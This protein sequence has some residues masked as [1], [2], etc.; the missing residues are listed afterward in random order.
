MSFTLAMWDPERGQAAGHLY[1]PASDPVSFTFF[2]DQANPSM[3]ARA[4]N[5][6]VIS[7]DEIRSALQ[8]NNVDSQR[9]AFVVLDRI[10]RWNTDPELAPDLLELLNGGPT[11][12]TEI[13]GL[14]AT[15]LS[16]IEKIHTYT[17]RP[18]SAFVPEDPADE[19][20][21]SR[22][23]ANWEL[24]L[25]L[26]SDELEPAALTYDIVGRYDEEP[27]CTQDDWDD[28]CGLSLTLQC[29]GVAYWNQGNE[30]VTGTWTVTDARFIIEGSPPELGEVLGQTVAATEPVNSLGNL[31]K[32]GGNWCG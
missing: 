1:G 2:Y 14:A 29:N 19:G 23:R 12:N 20:Q 25:G 11:A 21:V 18:Q 17:W 26:A 30:I 13:S 15:W 16:S 6:V 28:T 5:G 3:L 24:L 27:D 7:T 31:T 32:S 9:E 10:G 22:V 4:D 8:S